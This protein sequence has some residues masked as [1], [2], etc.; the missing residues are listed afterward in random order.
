L[1]KS[2]R[3]GEIDRKDGGR[4]YVIVAEEGKN[5]GRDFYHTEGEKEKSQ[6]GIWAGSQQ[7]QRMSEEKILT[8]SGRPLSG[9]L[10]N[11]RAI[12]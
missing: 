10:I 6:R 2:R 3:R 1:S 9:I 12:D 7:H 8:E 4:G 11:H 5:A